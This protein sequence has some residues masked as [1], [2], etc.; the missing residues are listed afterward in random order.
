VIGSDFALGKARQ[1]NTDTLKILGRE[2]DFSV[3]I[4]SPLTINGEVVSSTAI[5]KALAEGDM[6]KYTRLTGYSFSLRGKVVTG[7]GRGEGLGF[8]TANL[9]VSAGQ[10]IPPDGVYAGLAHI[11]SKVY[12]SMTNI[13]RNPTFGKNERTI[14]SYLLDYSGDLYGHEL[15]V[16]FISRLRDEIKFSSIE[17]LKKQVAEDVRKGKIIL[18][19]KGVKK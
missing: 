16:D 12:Q 5:R 14:E 19:S 17:E 9:E 10:A 11:N 15:S 3:T 7:A 18:D 2:L 8:P 4:V 13:G 1:G 6:E